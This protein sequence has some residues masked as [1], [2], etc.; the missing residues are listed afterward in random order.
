MNSPEVRRVI[1]MAEY[2]ERK[3]RRDLESLR[4]FMGD[5][6]W[7]I[8]SILS[9]AEFKTEKKKR[10]SDLRLVPKCHS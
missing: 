7:T 3:N 10:T 6:L 4:E 5:D 1:D 2:R 9:Q 8:P